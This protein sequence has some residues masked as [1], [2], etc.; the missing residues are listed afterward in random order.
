MGLWQPHQVE[1]LGYPAWLDRTLLESQEGVG[2][3]GCTDLKLALTGAL[4]VQIIAGRC[5]VRGNSNANHNQGLYHCFSDG[6]VV[7]TNAISANG[8]N[9]TLWQ[10]IARV[11]DHPEQLGT[12]TSKWRPEAIAGAPTSG[13]TLDNRNG[14]AALPQNSLLLHD[15]LVPAAAVSLVSGNV[16]DR[17]LFSS[18]GIIPPLLQ[19]IDA[20]VINPPMSAASALLA[21]A[22]DLTS[23]GLCTVPSR[24]S[25]TKLRW[26]Y[27]QP[28]TA[29]T[30]NYTHA[31]FDSSGRKIWDI[32]TQAF[33][34]IAN[35]IQSRS[36]TL[37][38]VSGASG[39]IEPGQ[40][41]YYFSCDSGSANVQ[42]TSWAN[43]IV[44]PGLTY[45]GPGSYTSA[46]VTLQT[47][48]S[49]LDTAVTG[50]GYFTPSAAL[51]VQ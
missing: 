25:P 27:R 42:V 8:S 34:G 50:T 7:P 1:D 23:I 4:G 17:R 22:T 20:V 44:V 33:T 37:N 40:Y 26:Q 48:G 14:A 35:S 10:I 41:L 47:L 49:L 16:R 9:P 28:G 31:L 45:S 18:D 51:S 12:E 46:P 36:E 24:I 21:S 32:G 5:Y 30:Y 11:Y 13:A 6:V 2:V 29:Q 39:V 38:F 43:G 3:V 15:V 19:N